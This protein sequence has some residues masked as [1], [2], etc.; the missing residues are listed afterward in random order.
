MDVLTDL[1]FLQDL[2]VLLLSAYYT[3]RTANALMASQTASVEAVQ[4]EQTLGGQHLAFDKRAS[5][6][7]SLVQAAEP[8]NLAPKN[9]AMSTSRTKSK[10]EFS[11]MANAIGATPYDVQY[12]TQAVQ[13]LFFRLNCSMSSDCVQCWSPLNGLQRTSQPQTEESVLATVNSFAGNDKHTS[14]SGTSLQLAEVLAPLPV[15]VQVGFIH[16]C[17]RPVLRSFLSNGLTKPMC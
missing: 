4:H 1:L 13:S 15:H 10:R 6:K 12:S 14:V 17:N 5:S 3:D 8:T 16:L 11:Y 9:P 7:L 2:C